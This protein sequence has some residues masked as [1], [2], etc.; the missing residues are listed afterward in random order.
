MEKECIPSRAIGLAF[1]FKGTIIPPALSNR[2]ISA[3]LCMWSVKEYHKEKLLYSGFVALSRDK[4]HDIVVCVKSNIIVVYIIHCRSKGLIVSDVATGV[5]ECMHITL[6]RISE[7]YRSTVSNE[8]TYKELPFHVEFAC[9][10]L[11][12]YVPETTS[13]GNIQL[14]PEHRNK[15]DVNVWYQDKYVCKCDTLCVGLSLDALS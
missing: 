10:D 15:V 1:V 13:F 12:Y 14:C 9:S 8:T 2:L 11:T 4:S 3:C 7:F 5:K 6:Q